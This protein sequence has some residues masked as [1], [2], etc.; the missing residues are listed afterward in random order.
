MSDLME[1]AEH[2][3]KEVEALKGEKSL[4]QSEIVMARESAAK[5]LSEAEKKASKI[6]E[7]ALS[8]AQGT[9]H[10]LK[11][12]EEAVNTSEKV[13]SQLEEESKRM[14]SEKDSLNKKSL[15][16]SKQIEELN[17]L[18]SD[19]ASKKQEVESLLDRVTALALE[20]GV[21]LEDLKEESKKE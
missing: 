13:L 15:E 5:I 3:K 14:G 21:K 17:H 11:V 6:V 9:Q 18:L 7:D 12:R 16:V 8:E 19:S 1:L 2:L 10:K 20:K 4:L